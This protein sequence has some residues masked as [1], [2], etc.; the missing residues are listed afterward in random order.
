MLGKH[1]LSL[2]VQWVEHQSRIA[3]LSLALELVRYLSLMLLLVS[4]D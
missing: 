4:V 2:L 3:V 1:L